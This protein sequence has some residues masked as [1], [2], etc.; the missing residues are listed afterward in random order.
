MFELEGASAIACPTR[1]PFSQEAKAQRSD[2][3]KFTEHGLEFRD[4]ERLLG[5]LSP[6]W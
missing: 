3:S 1:P 6:V 4:A 2:V 5:N